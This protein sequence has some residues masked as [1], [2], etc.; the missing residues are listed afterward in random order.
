[1]LNFKSAIL[2]IAIT[3]ILIFVG[4]SLHAPENMHS[5]SSTYGAKGFIFKNECYRSKCRKYCP[6]LD[7]TWCWTTNGQNDRRKSCSIDRNCDGF[8][9]CVSSCRL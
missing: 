6:A 9:I 7:K 3:A 4:Q 2:L 8:D 1:M 5:R